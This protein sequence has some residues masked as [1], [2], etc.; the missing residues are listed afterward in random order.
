MHARLPYPPRWYDNTLIVQL[1]PCLARPSRCDLL[2]VR[3]PLQLVLRCVTVGRPDVV[4]AHV[5]IGNELDTVDA[6]IATE[7]SLFEKA[8]TAH[9]HRLTQSILKVCVCVSSP[10]DLT[11]R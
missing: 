7:V 8:W 10:A 6:E 4:R 1:C 5:Y 11:R 2:C 9:E 3:A